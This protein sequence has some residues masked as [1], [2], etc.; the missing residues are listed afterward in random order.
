[1]NNGTPESD[2]VKNAIQKDIK[3]KLTGSQG[4]GK[5]F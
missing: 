3:D 5:L 4:A 1:M 2:D